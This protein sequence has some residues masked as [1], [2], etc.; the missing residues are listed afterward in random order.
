MINIDV[1][2]INPF[3]D[4][5]K[6][7]INKTHK[8][9]EN[10]IVETNLYKTNSILSLTLC[11]SA[12]TDHSGFRIQF[13]AFGYDAEIHYYDTRHADRRWGT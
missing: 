1:G 9:A 10:K 6:V 3:S 7:V 5:W 2:I 8:I 12:F 11:V 4:R 13:G